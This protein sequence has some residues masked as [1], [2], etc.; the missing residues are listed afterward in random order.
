MQVYIL[1][2]LKKKITASEPS[3][4]VAWALGPTPPSFY[5]QRDIYLSH[6]LLFSFDSLSNNLLIKIL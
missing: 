3:K 4:V 2:R 5:N 1:N 6:M